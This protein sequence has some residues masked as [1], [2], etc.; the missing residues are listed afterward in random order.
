MFCV[1]MKRRRVHVLCV[2]EEKEGA[3]FVCSW[4]EGGSMFC[5]FMK[6]RR[7]H[8]LCVHEEKEGPCFVCS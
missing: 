1:F 7:V 5:V 6:R 4:R 8:V 3:C 2:L